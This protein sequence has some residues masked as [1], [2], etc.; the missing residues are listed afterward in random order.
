MA[1]RCY[2]QHGTACHG[3]DMQWARSGEG[4]RNRFFV[5]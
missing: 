2:R 3:L 1:E 5:E 4:I